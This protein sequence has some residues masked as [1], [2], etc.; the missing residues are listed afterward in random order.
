MRY[1]HHPYNH[2]AFDKN[3]IKYA[4]IADRCQPISHSDKTENTETRTAR[5]NK[6]K[7]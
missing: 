3:S 7:K 6:A 2:F 4:P 5:K 1:R